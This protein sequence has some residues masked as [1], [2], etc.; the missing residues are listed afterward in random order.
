MTSFHMAAAITFIG[1]QTVMSPAM[2]EW[3]G[4]V[5]IQL[6]NDFIGSDKWFTHGSYA[7]YVS[8]PQEDGFW[9]IA[10]KSYEEIFN[11]DVDRARYSLSLGQN[12]YT[13]E[14]ISDPNLIPND[15]PYAGWTYIGFGLVVEKTDSQGRL[16]RVDNYEVNL[17]LVGPDSGGEWVQTT[18]HDAF[19]FIEP[20]GWD[21]QLKN[22]PTLNLFYERRLYPRDLRWDGDNYPNLGPFEVELAPRW[23]VALGNAFTYA[24]A[25]AVLR[26]GQNLND[27]H[28]PLIRPSLPGSG[29]FDEAEGFNWYVFAGVDLRATGYNIFLDG[30]TYRDSHSVDK[31][32]FVGDA[33]IGFAVTYKRARLAMTNIFRTDE[34]E[35]QGEGFNFRALT[36]SWRL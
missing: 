4:T 3:E 34:F 7:S 26:F 11:S 12:I 33:Q 1:L 30:N 5:S 17:G 9:D 24:S 2:A 10:E 32:I 15:R 23:G 29:Y 16:A 19:D 6:E 28:L 8:E 35:G 20:R 22:E 14:D 31:N 36:L 27:D 18:W 13:P 25:G 21:N